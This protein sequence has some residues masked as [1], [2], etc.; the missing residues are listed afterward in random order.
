MAPTSPT[1]TPPREARA[2]RV[3][4][5]ALVPLVEFAR[6]MGVCR[7][8]VWA[9]SKRR[10]NPLKVVRLGGRTYVREADFARFVQ[11]GIGSGGRA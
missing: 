10:H 9:W 6:V 5:V 2:I 8:T 7:E 3:G 11:G 4:T 1:T